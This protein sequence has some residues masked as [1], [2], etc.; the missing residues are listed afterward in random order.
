MRKVTWPEVGRR[1]LLV[2]H[3]IASSR[4]ASMPG[5]SEE[6]LKE[7]NVRLVAIDRPGYGESDKHP[8]QTYATFAKDID[9]LAD[10]LEL[11]EKIW[12]LGYSCGGAYCWGAAYYIPDRIAGIAMWAPVGNYWWKVIQF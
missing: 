2:V 6:L 1:S 5:V 12:L 7:L 8:Q 4:L 11:G 10:L 9:E 3:G